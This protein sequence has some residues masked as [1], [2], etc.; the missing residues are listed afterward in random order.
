LL[1]AFNQGGVEQL[2]A[3]DE[4]ESDLVLGATEAVN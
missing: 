2:V 1:D 3:A 4:V